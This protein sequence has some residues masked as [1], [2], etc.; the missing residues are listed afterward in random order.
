MGLLWALLGA[1]K[2]FARGDLV[3]TAG[4]LAPG[5]VA[6]RVEATWP[7]DGL[8]LFLGLSLLEGFF[9]WCVV[10]WRGRRPTRRLRLFVRHA[11]TLPRQPVPLAH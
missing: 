8:A 1:L 2:V 3:V 6:S 4:C 7:K 11:G 5:A 9:L 10:G